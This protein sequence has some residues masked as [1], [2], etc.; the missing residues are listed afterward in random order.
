MDGVDAEDLTTDVGWSDDAG[1]GRKFGL[2]LCLCAGQASILCC[3]LKFSDP[4]LLKVELRDQD[5]YY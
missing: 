3:L 5:N 2:D 1:E 4:G